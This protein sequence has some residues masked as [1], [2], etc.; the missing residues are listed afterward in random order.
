MFRDANN[1]N[2]LGQLAGKFFNYAIPPYT[3]QAGLPVSYTGAP[4][5]GAMV[6]LVQPRRWSRPWGLELEVA[7]STTARFTAVGSYTYG[8][9][10]W[11]DTLDVVLLGGGGGGDGGDWEFLFGETFGGTSGAWSTT[12]LVRGVDI[13][14]ETSTITGTVGVGG[15]G[16]IPKLIILDN[17]GHNGSATTATATGMTTLTAAGGVGGGNSSDTG[18]GAGQ[19]TFNGYL[20]RGG[21]DVT[22]AG[23][24][25]TTPGGGGAAGQLLQG[26]GKGAGGAVYIRAYQNIGGS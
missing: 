9:P 11:C 10:E 8:I 24:N 22:A 3:P 23:R 5:G 6:Q 17:S 21:G 12:T 2:L 14:W 19:Q 25:G 20:Y 13:P 1:T 18:Q 4:A 15:H 26:G 16:G 7:E